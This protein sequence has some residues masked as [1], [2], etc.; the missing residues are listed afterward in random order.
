MIFEGRKN[1]YSKAPVSIITMTEITTPLG[2][3]I[4]GATIEGVCLLE[5]TNRIRLEAEMRDLKKVLHANT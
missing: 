3:M 2:P 4:A 1:T 5:F